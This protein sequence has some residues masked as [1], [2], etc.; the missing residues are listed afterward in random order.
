MAE[1][2]INLT[3]QLFAGAIGGNTAGAALKDCGVGTLGN[4]I[5]G[6]IG[7]GVMG[8]V[9]QA[10]IPPL[11]GGSGGL[12]IGLLLAQM[13]GGFAGGATLAVIAGIA[14]SAMAGPEVH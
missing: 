3:V 6:V 11:A 1:A 14:K 9:L 10:L 7:G 12:E 8:Q 2:L 4:T 13:A 5:A